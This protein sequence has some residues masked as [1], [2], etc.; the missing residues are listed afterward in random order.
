MTLA[1]N[2][3]EPNVR[4]AVPFFSVSNMEASLRFYVDGLGF[5]MKHKWIDEGKLRWC[6]LEIGN[7]ALMLQEFKR[8]GH[9]SWTPE[10]KVGVGVNISF[11]C[12]DSLA[13]YREFTSR[14]IQAARP[15]VGNHMWV[16]TL[17]DPDGYR[18]EFKSPTDVPEE[19]LYAE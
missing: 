14:S 2:S 15:F 8:E 6:W 17:T 13:L 9:D 18:I 4:Q 19:T 10:G 12:L 7:A 11:Q 16:T 1:H 3:N 5:T